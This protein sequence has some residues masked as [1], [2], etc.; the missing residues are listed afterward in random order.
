MD[1]SRVRPSGEIAFMPM[2]EGD[3]DALNLKVKCFFEPTTTNQD[4]CSSE[5]CDTCD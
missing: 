4:R 3:K 5:R 1:E 2:S